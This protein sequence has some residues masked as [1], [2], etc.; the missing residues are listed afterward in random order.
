MPC[1]SRAISPYP[2]WVYV[3]HSSKKFDAT[4]YVEEEMTKFKRTMI[5]GVGSVAI[6]GGGFGVYNADQIVD[7]AT[8]FVDRLFCQPHGPHGGVVCYPLP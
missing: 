3:W 7:Q 1:V 4:T 8:H 5:A 2:G 6:L